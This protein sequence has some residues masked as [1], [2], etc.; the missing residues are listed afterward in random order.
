MLIFGTS[1]LPKEPTNSYTNVKIA[2][3]LK[4]NVDVERLI[5]AIE[6]EVKRQQI[7]RSKIYDGF[8]IVDDTPFTVKQ[9]KIDRNRY[10]SHVFNLQ[11]EI[12]IKANIY[13][14]EFTCVIDH[15]AFDGWSTSI[16]LD[17]IEAFYRGRICLNFLIN[18][19]ILL[20]VSRIF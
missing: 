11:Q 9:E 15:I 3:K 13:N 20:N 2:F 19:K 17:E 12:P 7:L 8:Q 6:K 4:P 5:I 14:G 10:F 16:F 18:T 1:V